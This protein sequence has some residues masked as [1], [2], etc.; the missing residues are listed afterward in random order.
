MKTN[1]HSK[2]TTAFTLVELVICIV[3]AVLLAQLTLSTRSVSLRTAQR[4][5]CTENLKFIGWGIRTYALDYEDRFPWD[6]PVSEGGTKELV[7]P[8]LSVDTTPFLSAKEIDLNQIPDPTGWYRTNNFSKNLAISYNFIA[9]S[10]ELADFRI[11]SCPQDV[12]VNKIII[13]Y[14][15]M[16]QNP[17]G[18]RYNISYFINLEATNDFDA[19]NTFLFGDRNLLCSRWPVM[20]NSTN[21]ILFQRGTETDSENFSDVLWTPVLHTNRGNVLLADGSV[22]SISN[23]NLQ[24][25][26]AQS[27]NSFNRIVLPFGKRP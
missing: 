5:S 15:D 23:T 11:I 1:I 24:S 3:F 9:F 26:L 18:G 16:L 13:K 6:V 2:R 19:P 8:F 22:L 25:Y 10:N 12:S 21:P 7:K 14:Q 20:T 27:T 4:I 17:N